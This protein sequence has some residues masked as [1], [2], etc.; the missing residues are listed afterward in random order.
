MMK[1]RSIVLALSMLTAGTA[2]GVAAQQSASADVSSGDRPVLIQI[3]PCRLADT[4]SNQQVG[5]QGGKIGAG[6]TVSFDV[7]H[8]TTD[9]VGLIP[10]DAVGVSTNITALGATELSYLT[11]W[12]GGDQP[13]AASLNPAPG[14]PPT[15]NAVTTGL[16][17][18]SFNIYNNAGATHVVIDVNGYYVN[19]THD[20][21]YGSGGATAGTFS[22]GSAAFQPRSDR[23]GWSKDLSLGASSGGAWIVSDADAG[24][25]GPPALAAELSLPDGAVITA[26]TAYFSDTTAFGGLNFQIR[27]E[28]FDGGSKIVAQGD[29]LSAPASGT[30]AMDLTTTNATVDNSTCSYYFIA[31][32]SNWATETDDLRVRGVSITTE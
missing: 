27:C 5:P 23:L 22:V 30:D 7:Q 25:A 15:P 32:G 9:C 10:T 12:P 8:P 24:A 18:G 4:R 21:L 29:T 14:E 28:E 1:S 2:V 3:S 20:D 16:G 11:I 17:G 6:E 26:A 19:H 13:L 31:E